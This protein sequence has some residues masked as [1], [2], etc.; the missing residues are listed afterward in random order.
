MILAGLGFYLVNTESEN[1]IL[2]RLIMTGV[3]LFFLSIALLL[4]VEVAW[5][6]LLK[7]KLLSYLLVVLYGILFFFTVGQVDDWSF[8]SF[9]FFVLH[10]FGFVASIFF[11]P[12]LKRILEKEEGDVVY[13]NYFMAISWNILMTKIVGISLFLLGVVAIASVTELFNLSYDFWNLYGNWA[14]FSFSLVA[15]LYFLAHLP[16]EREIDRNTFTLN[17]FFSFLVRFLAVPAIFVYFSILY[18]YSAKVLLNFSDWPKNIVTWLVIGFSVFGYL[19]YIFSRPYAE[20]R[21]IRFFRRCF[22]W[23]VVPQIGMLAYA[24][25]LRIGQY[26]LTMNRYFVVI[27]GAWLL[28]IS[29]YYIFSRK[30]HLSVFPLSLALIS[31]VISVGPWSVYSLPLSR[32]YDRL[33]ENLEKANIIQEGKI[34]PLTSPTDISKELSADIYSGID[35]VCNY[36]RC[37]RI[38][39]L[40][41]KEL[42]E[43]KPKYD[44]S[45]MPIKSVSPLSHW[46]IVSY[47]SEYIKVQ[48]SYSYTSRE[49]NKYITYSIQYSYEFPYPL[50]IRGYDEM[51]RVVGASDMMKPVPGVVGGSEVYPYITINPDTR[52]VYY[53]S[54]SGTQIP[55]VLSGDQ[56]YLD[57]NLPE[58]N[59]NKNDLLFQA[60]SDALEVQLHMSSYSIKN[61]KYSGADPTQYYQMNGV[62]LVKKK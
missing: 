20:E 29:L 60:N 36:S 15:P 3:V 37:E 35:Y 51:V 53:V 48:T 11:A 12:Y 22:P 44:A 18:A 50:P 38:K 24:I 27:F 5:K 54:G 49:T 34:V 45:G 8:E 62:A 46:E 16:H 32:Q 42:S 40:F 41:E 7:K 1:E 19:A 33:I 9:V 55:L 17:R 26:D 61:P 21:M 25:I 14:I 13:T 30:K 31:I 43:R 23:V 57:G 2:F 28:G 6:D 47:I 39:K 4:Y 59:L 58:S 56:K 10:L 52:E